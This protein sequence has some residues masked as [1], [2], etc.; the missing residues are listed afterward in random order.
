MEQTFEYPSIS[1]STSLP[2]SSTFLKHK[3]SFIKMSFE[4]VQ[5]QKNNYIQSMIKANFPF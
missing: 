5:K 3:G 1:I 2:Y 4:A